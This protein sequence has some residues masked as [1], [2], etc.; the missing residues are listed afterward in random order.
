VIFSFE[1]IIN[2]AD[3][4]EKE[5][6]KKLLKLQKKCDV[7]N[8]QFFRKKRVLRKIEVCR[9]CSVETNYGKC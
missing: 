7:E 8:R 1:T 3:K 4:K 2:F 6:H 5:G 9:E